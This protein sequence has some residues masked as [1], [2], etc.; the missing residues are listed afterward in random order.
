M[1]VPD[2]SSGQYRWNIDFLFAD[3]MG[4]PTFVECKRFNDTASRRSVVGQMMEYAANGHYYWTASE[5]LSYA[6]QAA[7]DR[8]NSLE[9]ELRRVGWDNADEPE[10]YFEAVELYLREGQVRLV[11]F[12]EEASFELKSIV[13]FLNNQMN[14]SEVLLVEARQFRLGNERLISPALFGFTEEARLLKSKVNVEPASGAQWTAERFFEK[15][16]QM[17]D[18]G[19]IEVLRQLLSECERLGCVTTWGKG[20]QQGT[21]SIKFPTVCSQNLFYVRTDGRFEVPFGAMGKNERD[22]A[23][24]SRLKTILT[25]RMHLSVPEEY[26]TRFPGFTVEQWAPEANSLVSELRALL[27]EGTE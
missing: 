26:E 24:R 22:R 23:V 2:P 18:P 21:Y 25:E 6:E 4:M 8:G 1:P 10:T 13:E 12:L 17:L 16:E 27:G 5:L 20:K 9:E 15:A 7:K 19:N 11:F 3:Q 14:R